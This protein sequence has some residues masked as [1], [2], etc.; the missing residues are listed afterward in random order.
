M[1][2]LV[3]LTCLFILAACTTAPQRK[4][5]AIEM[6]HRYEMMFRGHPL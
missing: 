4:P 2:K 3:L 6:H 1:L 5:S